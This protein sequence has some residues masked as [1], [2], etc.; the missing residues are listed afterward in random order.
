MSL[1]GQPAQQPAASSPFSFGAPAASSAPAAQPAPSLFGAPAAP[2]PAPLSLF[3]ASASQAAPAPTALAPAPTTNLFGTLGQPAA[4]STATPAPSL[5]GSTAPK[6]LFGAAPSTS[7]PTAPTTV[8]QLGAS[9]QTNITKRSKLSDLPE[10]AR[11]AVEGIETMIRSQIQV[12]EELKTRDLGSEISETSNLYQQYLGE[13][14]A[15][16]VMLK[17]DSRQAAM[18]RANLESDLLDLSRV[19]A[20]IEGFKSP[21]TK[22]PAAKA[23]ANFPFEYFSRKADDFRE[24]IAR[25]KVSMDQIQQQLESTHTN[26]RNPAAIVPTLRAQNASFMS[27]AS[28]V[29]S[30]DNDLKALKDDYRAIWREK[31]GSVQDPFARNG[32]AKVENAV[33]RMSI[34]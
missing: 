19:T 25:Y 11:L 27:L 22:G 12:S 32:G 1:F 2:K 3:G 24:K 23:V 17:Q 7:T 6:P 13:S 20:L 31:T 8:P 10:A 30:L 4:A 26:E 28:L 34:R 21:S 33:A 16:G 5:F 9:T 15:V 14:T 18:I 29:A